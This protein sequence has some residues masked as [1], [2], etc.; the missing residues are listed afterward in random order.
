MSSIYEFFESGEKYD[1]TQIAADKELAEDIQIILIWLRLLDPP[2]DGKFGPISSEAFKKFQ[3]YMDCPS[4]GILDTETA[5]KLIETDPNELSEAESKYFEDKSKLRLSNSL[6]SR[7]V[8]YML[9]KDYDIYTRPGEYNIVY[10][11]GMNADGTENSDAPNRFNDRRMVIEICDG[12]PVIVGNWEATTEPGTYYTRYPMRREGAARIQFNQF[13]AWQVGR[14]GRRYPQ[15]PALRQVRPITV[16][17]D[18]NRDGT[19]T[20]DKLHT[21]WFGINQHHA[22]N[23]PRHDIGRWSAG[24]LVGRTVASHNEFMKIVMQD[25]RYKLNNKYI[26]STTIIPGDDLLDKFPMI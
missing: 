24:C 11:E 12:V 19:R 10:V 15:Y 4:E 7:I 3:R 1:L 5:K 16:H 20:N 17:R 14:H 18:F 21:G 6:A 23:A 8:S 9:L 26:F 2:V 22:N 25:R 13:K